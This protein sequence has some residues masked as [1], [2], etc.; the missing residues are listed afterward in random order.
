MPDDDSN[1]LIILFLEST[2][3]MTHLLREEHA[4]TKT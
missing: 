1:V 4:R 2:Y 3:E